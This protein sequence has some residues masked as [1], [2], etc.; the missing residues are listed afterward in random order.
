[1]RS[2][3][4][5]AERTLANLVTGNSGGI[6]PT[7]KTVDVPTILE[8][9]ISTTTSA[10]IVLDQAIPPP[11]SFSD[12]TEPISMTVKVNP[13][14]AKMIIGSSFTEDRE[15]AKSDSSEPQEDAR[16]TKSNSPE[17]PRQQEADPDVEN[18]KA[19]ITAA[20]SREIKINEKYL[21]LRNTPAPVQ[22][23]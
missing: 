8:K 4:L 21:G 16:A 22:T 1:M 2:G 18:A 20:P 17:E 5:G 7:Q 23:S 15:M 19:A 12:N 13:K 9:T 14:Y 11:P 10:S 6:E 3:F